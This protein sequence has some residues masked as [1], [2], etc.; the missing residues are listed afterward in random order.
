MFKSQQGKTFIQEML[1]RKHGL[2]CFKTPIVLYY[3]MINLLSVKEMR[4]VKPL[5]VKTFF[6]L[7]RT[8]PEAVNSL[9]IKIVCLH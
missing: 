7:L 6:I 3:V 8:S 2:N 4:C 5:Y 1:S 9:T